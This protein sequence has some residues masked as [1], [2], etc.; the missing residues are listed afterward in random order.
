MAIV[1]AQDVLRGKPDPQ[2]Y[3][4]AIEQLSR[5]SGLALRADKT[6]VVEDSPAGI[7]SGKAAGMKVLAVATSYP[8]AEL[9]QA[10]M[11]VASLKD[12][13]ISQLGQLAK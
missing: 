10:D 7:A 3:Q 13:T 8:P 12:V 11:I 2:G 9:A 5:L 6:V 1:A 4:M